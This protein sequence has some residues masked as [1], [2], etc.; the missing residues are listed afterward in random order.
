MA[1]SL[2]V[3][4]KGAGVTNPTTGNVD[5]TGGNLLVVAVSSYSAGTTV[6]D[7]KSNSWTPLTV[8][9]FGEARTFI[10]YSQGGTFGSG[11]NFT[12]TGS[13]AAIEGA[14]FSGSASSPFD[15]QNTN[16]S[17]IKV[18]SL[19]TGSVTPSQNDSLIIATIATGGGGG[20]YSID[21]GFTIIDS[22]DYVAFTN[23]GG[24]IAYKIQTTAGAENPTW[25]WTGSADAAASIAVFKPAAGAT[26][27]I[28]LPI[29][30]NGLGV[31]GPFFANPL[32]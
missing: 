25:S 11:E 18:T 14:A 8:S 29:P 26:G 30:M 7:A 31:G 13:Y 5:T 2:L 15:V 21:S 10:T 6:S 28:F 20:G 3:H 4:T 27:K 9:T 19:S 24:A 1:F 17:A 32:G 12:Y 16:A 23:E 22:N